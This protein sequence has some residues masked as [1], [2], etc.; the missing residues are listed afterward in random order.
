MHEK[1]AQTLLPAITAPVDL[2]IPA[3]V[4]FIWDFEIIAGLYHLTS[5]A[6]ENVW[7]NRRVNPVFTH[8][9]STWMA[10]N[11]VPETSGSSNSKYDEAMIKVLDNV[12]HVRTRP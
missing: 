1:Q 9:W 6:P 11:N 7:R 4:V 8:D 3:S 2:F 10:E 5:G 12:Q